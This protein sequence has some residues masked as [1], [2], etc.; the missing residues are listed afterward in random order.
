MN[1]TSNKYY[2][3]L[4]RYAQFYIPLLALLLV[5]LIY[6]FNYVRTQPLLL[7]PESYYHLSAFQSRAWVEYFPLGMLVSFIPE[8]AL[9]VLP[10]LLTLSSLLLLP[11]LLSRLGIRDET[12]FL[13]SIILVLTPTFLYASSTLSAA[14]LVLFLLAVG[15]VLLTNE[16]KR[17]KTLAFVPFSLISFIDLFSAALTLILLLLYRSRSRQREGKKSII[18][19]LWILTLLLVVNA[20]LFQE[21]FILGPFHLQEPTAD[22]ISDFGGIS[23]IGFTIMLLSI[24][25]ILL[26]WHNRHYRWMYGVLLGLLAAY[27]YSAQTILYL[28]IVIAFFAALGF[29]ALFGKNWKQPTLKMFTLL[30]V[31]LSVCFSTVSYL[32]RIPATGPTPEDITTLSW[33][34]D[35]IPP[36]KKIVALPEQGYYVRYFSGH[37]PLYEPHQRERKTLEI[38][39]LNSTYI[40][41]TFP[42]LEE[43]NVGA[44]Y[45]T[46][47]W[48]EQYPA[49]QG[50]LLFLLK[51]E[52]F[53]LGYS[54]EGYE[55]WRFE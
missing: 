1:L 25:G 48:K 39:V 46:P 19:I 11:V 44:V 27:I 49:D 41:T 47:D 16:E 52:R 28:S 20:L 35:N 34:E 10:L 29:Q 24:I 53:K 50:G 13:F 12:R 32:Q 8:K 18:T 42:I 5:G 31:I 54:S 6:L 17:S 22:L 3:H 38:T 23:G 30:L 45:V 7:G 15:F 21:A 9:F 51:N 37:E 26:F 4:L 40:D 33:I 36:G 55:V 43:Q 2:L 14:M